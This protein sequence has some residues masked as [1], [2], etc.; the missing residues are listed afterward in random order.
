MFHSVWSGESERGRLTH[1]DSYHS[2]RENVKHE[3]NE[4]QVIKKGALSPANKAGKVFKS[5][6]V[7]PCRPR[8]VSSKYQAP[9]WPLAAPASRLS[10]RK[11]ALRDSLILLPSLPMHLTMIC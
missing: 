10:S 2:E 9:S 1:S 7:E 3:E 6:G 4:E 5:T 11:T 8:V